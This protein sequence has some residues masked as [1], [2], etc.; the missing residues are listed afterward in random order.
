MNEMTKQHQPTPLSTTSFS[1]HALALLLT[2]PARP[3]EVVSRIVG[4]RACERR[5]VFTLHNQEF[6]YSTNFACPL[7]LHTPTQPQMHRFL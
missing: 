2:R 7:R 5:R 1:C 6:S 4:R 3:R